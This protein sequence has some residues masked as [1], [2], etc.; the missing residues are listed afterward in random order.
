MQKQH[1]GER[2]NLLGFQVELCDHACTEDCLKL[3]FCL[4]RMDEPSPFKASSEMPD[5]IRDAIRYAKSR[6]KRLG[7]SAPCVMS[8]G[9]P[10][11]HP[12][13]SSRSAK[14]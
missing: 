4:D 13:K 8:G 10:A 7:A 6:S 9:M 5:S 3:Q 11:A 1:E 12:T 14:T 2:Y